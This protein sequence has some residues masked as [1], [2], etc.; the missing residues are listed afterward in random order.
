MLQNAIKLKKL[1]NIWYK[2]TSLS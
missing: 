2:I 1:I